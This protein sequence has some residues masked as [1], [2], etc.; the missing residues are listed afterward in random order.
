M[1][2]DPD[3]DSQYGSGSMTA[4]SLRIYADPDQDDLQDFLVVLGLPDDLKRIRIGTVC[5]TD[6][7][8][9]FPRFL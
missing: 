9:H 4:N 3:P 7:G 2:L 1:F 5:F 8:T 6:E